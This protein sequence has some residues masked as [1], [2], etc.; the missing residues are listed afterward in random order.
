M[1]RSEYIYVVMEG[2]DLLGAFTVKHELQS[3]AEKCRWVGN[4]AV[5]V[6]RLKD[7][8]ERYERSDPMWQRRPLKDFL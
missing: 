5:K 6:I 3:C 2:G 8:P 4:D 7:G 1:A